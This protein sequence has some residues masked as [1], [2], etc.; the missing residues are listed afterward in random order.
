M[1][2]VAS[3][4]ANAAASQITGGDDHL[5]RVLERAWTIGQRALVGTQQENPVLLAC[6]VYDAGAAGLMLLLD[7][8]LTVVT[9]RPL[10]SA[11]DEGGTVH[12]MRDRPVAG[13]ST[14]LELMFE[15]STDLGWDQARV[16][17]RLGRLGDSVAVTGQAGRWI[18]HVHTDDPPSVVADLS[19][20]GRVAN[21]R[22]EPL[23][24]TS[25]SVDD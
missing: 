25:G 13:S 21:V 22:V 8:F 2:T 15:F 11:R 16:V 23:H 1:L 7:A 14:R 4:V 24:E 6:G 18:C 20:S 17:R 5:D 9:E 12:A 19:Q 10:P 3:V